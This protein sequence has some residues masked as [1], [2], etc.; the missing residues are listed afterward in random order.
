MAI[1][2]LII[3]AVIVGVVLWALGDILLDDNVWRDR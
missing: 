1:A 3:A 2:A